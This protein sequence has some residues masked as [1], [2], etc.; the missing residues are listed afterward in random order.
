MFLCITKWS[1][2]CLKSICHQYKAITLLTIFPSVYILSTHLFVN[3]KFVPLD[4]YHLFHSMTVPLSSS[5]HLFVL[6]IDDSV[7]VLCFFICVCVC[8]SSPLRNILGLATLRLRSKNIR[9]AIPSHYLTRHMS[10]ADP[11]VCL[12]QWVL[13][14]AAL[15]PLVPPFPRTLA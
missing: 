8:V 14:W 7:S 2:S 10:K 4:L 9:V 6:C 12:F 5:N 11:V 1:I 13:S 3:F 15:F